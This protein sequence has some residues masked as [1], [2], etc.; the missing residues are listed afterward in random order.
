M[1]NAASSRSDDLEKHP[2]PVLPVSGTGKRVDTD[3]LQVRSHGANRPDDPVYIQPHTDAGGDAYY[4]GDI[5]GPSKCAK[6]WAIDEAGQANMPYL[7]Y[8][9]EVSSFMPHLRYL[10]HWMEVTCAPPKWKFIKKNAQNRD[11]R[12]R[13]CKVCVLDFSPQKPPEK[14]VYT[15]IAALKDAL[16]APPTASGRVPDRLIIVE[17]LS[18]DVVE[19]LGGKYD[20]DPLFFLSHI[21]DYLF[22]N[23]RD[24]WVEMPDLDVI[25]RQRSF[26]TLQYLRGRYFSTPQD[27]EKAERESGSFNVLRRLDSDRS[28]ERLQNGLLDV[29]GASATLTRTKTSWWTRPSK[30]TDEPVLAILLVDPTVSAGFPLWNGPRP[31]E[32][33]PS[34]MD[35]TRASADRTAHRTSLFDDAV[36]WSSKIGTKELQKIHQEPKC[37]AIPMLQLVLAD[38][39]TVLKYMTTM[40]GKIEWEF[41]R[42]HWGEATDDIDKSLRKLSPWMRNMHYYKAMVAEAIDRL[43]PPHERTQFSHDRQSGSQAPLIPLDHDNNT[44]GGTPTPSS[45]ILSLLYDFYLVQ[46]Q[47]ETSKQRIEGIQAM[48]TNTINIEEAR[49]AV[50]QNKH[51]ARLT[52]LAT[53]F[54]PLS[55][56]SSFLSMSP[57]FASPASVTTVW[58]FFALGVPLTL[59]AL[60]IVDVTNPKSGFLVTTLRRWGVLPLRRGESRRGRSEVSD[61]VELGKT[62]PFFHFSKTGVEPSRRT[63]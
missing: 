59:S 60:V 53:I 12:A 14:P 52:L 3:S 29:N 26:F 31:F 9:K 24:P 2:H 61:A 58:L 48:A 13:R 41:E 42:P 62:I 1:G 34:M 44:H 30:G 8:V 36:Y 6:E 32:S 35:L 15:D 45:G 63:R 43:F 54:I 49:R 56:T 23:T 16:D 20:I 10:A 21:G 25:A 11:E 38:W 22:H 39:R 7:R 33:T 18:R 5:Y 51:L 17:D 37:F 47:M 27:F 4:I 28:R 19:L 55:F 40:L 57:G 50:D 46:Q